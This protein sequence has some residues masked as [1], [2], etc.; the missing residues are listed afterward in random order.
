MVNRLFDPGIKR[1][2]LAA[3]QT[4]FTGRLYA[5]DMFTIYRAVSG[6]YPTYPSVIGGAFGLS[7]QQDVITFIGAVGPFGRFHWV[8]D[9]YSIVYNRQIQRDLV[10]LRVVDP[11]FWTG[12]D[13]FTQL[14]E[15]DADEVGAPLAF[16]PVLNFELPKTEVDVSNLSPQDQALYAIYRGDV[17]TLEI[18]LELM[19]RYMP[20][21]L[22]TT[23]LFKEDLD[24]IFRLYGEWIAERFLG[25]PAS[26]GARIMSKV[27]LLADYRWYLLCGDLL[28]MIEPIF[29]DVG[30]DQ[31]IVQLATL[32]RLEAERISLVKP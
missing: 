4:A 27:I 7:L 22:L 25:R 14:L 28:S 20:E 5:W 8:G 12:W 3:V 18:L 17:D 11:S 24:G 10:P 30:F 15:E 32:M 13:R 31:G 29:L 1:P 16:G 21:T 19:A 9:V 23:P 2:N 6:L 26:R